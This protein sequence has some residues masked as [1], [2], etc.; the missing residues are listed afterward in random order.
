[1][2][3]GTVGLCGSLPRWIEAPAAFFGWV[4]TSPLLLMCAAG[5]R[6]SS[7][8]PVLIRQVRVGRGGKSFTLLKFR[9]MRTGQ[10]GVQ[11]TRAGDT[12]ITAVGRLLRKLKLDELPELWNVVRGDLSLVGPRP[13][14]PRFVDLQSALWAAVLT[15][16]PGITDP[17]TLRLRNEEDLLAKAED[18]E[19]FYLETLQPVKLQGYVEYL[20]R[21]TAWTDLV[22]LMETLLAVAVPSIAPPPRRED[23]AQDPVDLFRLRRWR[24]KR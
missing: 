17:V 1:M 9:T 18:P 4:V 2:S 8:G 19:R 11:V 24:V 7:P 10:G 23:L 6:L 12:R 20:R 14:V 16:R 5:V 21:R 3:Q 13:E 15:A 22:V